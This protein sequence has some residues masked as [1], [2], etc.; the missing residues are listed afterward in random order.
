MIRRAPPKG[1][2]KRWSLPALP[3]SRWDLTIFEKGA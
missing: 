3:L 1:S 2:H